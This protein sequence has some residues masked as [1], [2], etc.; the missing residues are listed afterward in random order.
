MRRL[1]TRGI[2]VIPLLV[3]IILGLE[4]LDLL[5]YSQVALSLLIPLPLLP[6]IYY[7]ADRTIMG[8]LASR[9]ITT[10]AASLFAL[11]IL[12]FNAYLIYATLGGH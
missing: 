5:V 3:A 12:S 7:S 4:P 9:R 11:L 10:I 1:I 6:L 8:D 2:N